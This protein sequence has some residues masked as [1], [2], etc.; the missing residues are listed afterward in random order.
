M[1]FHYIANGL[2]VSN[3]S[4]ALMMECEGCKRWPV[5]LRRL[6]LNLWSLH[7][8][9]RPALILTEDARRYLRFTG[10]V[11]VRK[12]GVSPRQ[13]AWKAVMLN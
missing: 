1:L 2:Y 4:R 9:V 8:D 6:R 7:R 11:V 3:A 13:T 10:K 12:L 5:M